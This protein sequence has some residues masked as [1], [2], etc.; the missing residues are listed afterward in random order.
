VPRHQMQHSGLER[1]ILGSFHLALPHMRFHRVRAIPNARV[2][3]GG[4]EID[5][6]LA[7]R[8]REFKKQVVKQRRPAA[9]LLGKLL[10]D[11]PQLQEVTERLPQ[12]G[13][14][15]GQPG[16][17]QQLIHDVTLVR[18]NERDLIEKQSPYAS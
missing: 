14:G 1:L 9:R 7:V 11:G 6:V 5:L 4:D 8:H 13:R 10:L 16:L 12:T 3:D 17:P 15:R 2:V 18:P